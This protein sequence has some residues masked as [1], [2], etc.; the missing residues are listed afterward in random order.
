M[1]NTDNNLNI[2]R[3][4]EELKVIMQEVLKDYG[5][6]CLRNSMIFDVIEKFEH[7][8]KKYFII[9]RAIKDVIQESLN[10]N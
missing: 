9:R 10:I 6:T 7:K 1:Q 8:L 2:D 4:T 3:I 5:V